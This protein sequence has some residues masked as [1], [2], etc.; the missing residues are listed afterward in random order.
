MNPTLHTRSLIAA[1]R[2]VGECTGVPAEFIFAHALLFGTVMLGAKACYRRENGQ[3][4]QI[5]RSPATIL[6]DD[7]RCPAWFETAV[8]RAVERQ[9]TVTDRANRFLIAQPTPK[10][11]NT[12]RRLKQMYGPVEDLIPDPLQRLM[13][14]SVPKMT[15]PMF[16]FLHDVAEKGSIRSQPEA[17]AFGSDLIALA[18][19]HRSHADLL[20]KR[21]RPN[22]LFAEA[23]NPNATTRVS[24]HGWAEFD[25]VKKLFRKTGFETLPP[26]GWLLTLPAMTPLPFVADH[27]SDHYRSFFNHLFTLRMDAPQ[28]FFP[29]PEIVELLD[30]AVA[31]QGSKIQIAGMGET[32][33]NPHPMLPWQLATVLWSIERTEHKPNPE[34]HRPLAELACKVAR[35]IH[36]G[37]IHTLRRIFPT[38]ENGT[39]NPV[40]AAIVD[41]LAV[42]PLHTRELVR[43]FHRLSTENLRIRLG[44]LAEDGIVI[45][46]EDDDG[47]ET[48]FTPPFDVGKSRGFL[49]SLSAEEN[50][51]GSS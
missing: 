32:L 23:G 50:G 1:C 26:F 44:L 43:Q 11:I 37:H 5:I 47:N 20:G 29:E 8:E 15:V 17:N 18:I 6:T 39:T 35:F 40:D 48:W 10:Q 14:T 9:Q 38:P 49:S 34:N 28:T 4:P 27:L 42:K 24:I 31:E 46:T 41:K 21:C 51:S 45:R 13:R 16:D 25:P 2:N 7:D 36:A 19:G 3:P 33:L 22:S 12:A 30:H